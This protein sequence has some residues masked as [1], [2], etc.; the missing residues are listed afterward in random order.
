MCFKGPDNI[1]INEVGKMTTIGAVSGAVSGGIGE[2]GPAP[3]TAAASLGP[4]GYKV[5]TNSLVSTV[6]YVICD[7]FAVT[8]QGLL[9]AALAGA[10]TGNEYPNIY[11]TLGLSFVVE[12]GSYYPISWA[13]EQLVNDFKSSK[14]T[15]APSASPAPKRVRGNLWY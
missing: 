11:I 12:V 6:A 3:G 2:M 10:V 14:S 8:P 7:P 4:T 13:L 15:S 9:Y 1:D 5:V